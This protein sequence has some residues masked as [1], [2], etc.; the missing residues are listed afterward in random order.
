MAVVNTKDQT[1]IDADAS[2]VVL[3]ATRNVGFRTRKI[4]STLEVAVSDDDNS[5]YRLFRVW[6]RWVIVSLLLSHDTITSGTDYNFGLYDINAGSIVGGGNVYADAQNLSTA[7]S[8]IELINSQRD[9]ADLKNQVFDDAG[10]SADT[11]QQYDICATAITVGSAIG[12][13]SCVLTY[14]DGT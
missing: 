7:A 9:I 4:I 3:S 1:L 11:E 5:V 8:D 10:A 13:I 14:S 6:S 2:P 12:T